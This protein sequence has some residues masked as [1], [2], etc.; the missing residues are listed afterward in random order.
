MVLKINKI[1]SQY[2]QHCTQYQLRKFATIKLTL[3]IHSLLKYSLI[4]L[5]ITKAEI[6]L[7]DIIAFVL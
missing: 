6:V 7:I 5:K 1:L 4:V 3:D 2:H